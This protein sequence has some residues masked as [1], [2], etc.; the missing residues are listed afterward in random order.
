MKVGDEYDA[1]PCM[2]PMI[3]RK[4]SQ[5]SKAPLNNPKTLQNHPVIRKMTEEAF[6]KDSYHIPK[7]NGRF[8]CSQDDFLFR[9]CKMP[10]CMI[11]LLISHVCTK[12]KIVLEII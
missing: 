11:P 2:T 7:Y 1:H 6:N 8:C 12:K 10:I 5:F 3:I 9:L 4:L